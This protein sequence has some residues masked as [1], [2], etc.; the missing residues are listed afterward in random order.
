MAN[1]YP[2]LA[3]VTGSDS[4]I[5]RATATLLASEGFDVGL[6]FHRDE[7]GI[8][9][10]AEE[11][12]SRGQRSFVEPFDASSPDAG[13]VVDRLA[14][15]LGGLSVLVN[16]AGTGHS[17]RAIDLDPDTW[18]HVLATDLDGPFLCAQ[19]AARRMIEQDRGGRIV[20]VTSVHEHLPRLGA[21][22]YCA[23][24][25]GLGMLTKVMALELAEHGITV[26]SVA[27]G[28]I[29]TPMTGQDESEAY[30]LERPGNPLGRPGH[31]NEVAS[32]IAFLASPRSAY[33]TGSS[34]TVD[35]GLSL[36]AAHGHDTATGWREI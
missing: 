17:D 9:H 14:D 11:V 12:A 29:S 33:V 22:A 19:R 18:R 1:N 35:G 16:V 31:V 36:M 21:A 13:S 27:P 26:N 34:Y 10:T 25:A 8:R 2:R 4:G 3:I 7:E 15:Q 28:E 24:K 5:G 6:T 20:N 32:V 30:H 23:A